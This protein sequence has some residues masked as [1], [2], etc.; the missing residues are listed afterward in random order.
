[1]KRKFLSTT[2]V[3]TLSLS[4]L[5]A[6]CGGNNGNNGAASEATNAPQ[7]A[8]PTTAAE[9]PKEV[10]ALKAFFPGDKPT[11]FDDVLKAVNE[12]LKADNVGA[13]L[14]INFLPWS[15]YGN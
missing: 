3:A 8:E 4:M 2:L 11:G 13:S 14:N 9:T 15:D 12:K 5:L 7:T 1:M 6:G 10:V